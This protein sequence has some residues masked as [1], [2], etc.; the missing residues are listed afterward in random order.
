MSGLLF[1]S[2]KVE[3]KLKMSLCVFQRDVRADPEAIQQV[4]RATD[5]LLDSLGSLAVEVSH[6]QE[7]RLL[8]VRL[9]SQQPC[10]WFTGPVQTLRFSLAIS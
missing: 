6:Q 2:A 4:A 9:I 3:L 5:N 1:I 8:L 10:Y 7:L